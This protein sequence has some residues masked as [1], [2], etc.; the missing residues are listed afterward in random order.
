MRKP[1][2][3]GRRRDQKRE[4]R[5]FEQ[6]ILELARV[7]RVTKGGKRMRFRT[8]LIIGDRKGRVGM[9]VAKGAD[10]AMSIEKAFRKAKKNLVHIPLIEETVPHEVRMKFGA[11]K[12]ILKPAPK[13][14][15]LKSGGAVRMVLELGGVPNAVTKILGSSNKINN[16]K[17]TFAALRTLKSVKEVEAKKGTGK[18]KDEKKEVPKKTETKEKQAA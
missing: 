18:K 12:I 17:A 4:P 11:A 15:G 5:E 14:T 7:T 3:R 9:G 13:G 1:R 8:C 6:K 2:G 16:A 10:V